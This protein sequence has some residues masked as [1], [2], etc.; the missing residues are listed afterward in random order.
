MLNSI[1]QRQSAD[2]IAV[3]K[4]LAQ[5]FH[6]GFLRIFVFLLPLLERE[7]AAF[8]TFLG[9]DP[10]GLAFQALRRLNLQ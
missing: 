1:K 8:D 6:T 10:F 4:Q 3:F 5:Y 9:R 2:S 7:L